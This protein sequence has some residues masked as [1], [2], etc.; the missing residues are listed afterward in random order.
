MQDLPWINLINAV[1]EIHISVLWIQGYN[2]K[3]PCANEGRRQ[4]MLSN[5]GVFKVVCTVCKENT[6]NFPCSLKKMVISH[7]KE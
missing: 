7:L 4:F 2:W 1:L 3:S 5:V 6:K